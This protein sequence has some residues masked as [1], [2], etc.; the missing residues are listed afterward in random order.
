VVYWLSNALY[1]HF[2]DVFMLD[3]V[4]CGKNSAAKA[5]FLLQTTERKKVCANFSS[6]FDLLLKIPGVK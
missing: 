2:S 5:T 3:R 4:S 1:G 6:L